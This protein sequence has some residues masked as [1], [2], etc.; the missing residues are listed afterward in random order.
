M[1]SKKKTPLYVTV[2]SSNGNCYDA[3]IHF[4]FKEVEE[5]IL[6]DIQQDGCTPEELK[7]FKIGEEIP[8]EY[9]LVI[10]EPKEKK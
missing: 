10:T 9:K 4:S 6:N 1:S 2:Y 5:Q 7:V 3:T 8:F